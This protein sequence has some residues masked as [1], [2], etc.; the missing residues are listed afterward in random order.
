M[1][2]SLLTADFAT[3]TA[4]RKLQAS[5]FLQLPKGW[6]LAASEHGDNDDVKLF[7]P[8]TITLRRTSATHT[9]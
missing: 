3:A 8:L 6:A 9:T 5:S 7:F 2:I 1:F 4:R